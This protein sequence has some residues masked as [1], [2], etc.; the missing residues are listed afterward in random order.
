MI[1]P[2]I[3]NKISSKLLNILMLQ[4]QENHK[5][6]LKEYNMLERHIIQVCAIAI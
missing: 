1:D 3:L 2:I 6:M 4:V 5:K